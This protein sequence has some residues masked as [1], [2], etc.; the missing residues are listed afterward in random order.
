[1]CLMS[2]SY[3]L[4]QAQEV[5]RRSCQ[6]G[7]T[8][9]DVRHDLLQWQSLAT[10]EQSQ[11]LASS[12]RQRKRGQLAMVLMTS[13]RRRHREPRSSRGTVHPLRMQRNSMRP[14][15]SCKMQVVDIPPLH[16]SLGQREPVGPNLRGLCAHHDSSASHYPCCA[17]PKTTY[18]CG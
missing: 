5:C 6:E 8:Y 3:L 15:A 17:W 14:G 7:W 11:P 18:W 9:I 16:C 13:S 10:S 4:L 12:G 2:P 1:M